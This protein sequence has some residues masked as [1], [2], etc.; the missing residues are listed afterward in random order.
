MKSFDQFVK[1]N[2][3]VGIDTDGAFGFQCMDLMH[4]YCR[5][6]LGL[7]DLAILAQPNAKS[8]YNNFLNVKGH[9]LFDKIAN[10]P[11]GIPLKGDIILY[12][13]G[14]DGHV[15]IFIQ[16]D[17]NSFRSFSQNFPTGSKS[18][19]VNH[20]N[21]NGVLGWL[22]L[23]PQAPTVPM[24]TITQAELDKIILARDTNWNS[25]EKYRIENVTLK[26]K[27]IKYEILLDQIVAG[28]EAVRV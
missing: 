4:A 1:D 17:I 25:S 7:S 16:G 26:A 5:D 18:I 13:W 21:Y 27:T 9:E 24:A 15:D 22:R 6:V 8:V 28:I 11:T 23:K 19:V 12:D 10:T 2:T 20:P 14:N 3:N